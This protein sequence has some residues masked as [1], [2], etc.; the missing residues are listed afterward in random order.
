MR[1][2]SILLSFALSVFLGASGALGVPQ[3]AEE[4]TTALT[5][6][7]PICATNPTEHDIAVVEQYLNSDDDVD[8]D[9]DVDM[10]EMEEEKSPGDQHN[11]PPHHKKCRWK[12]CKKHMYKPIKVWFHIVYANKTREGGWIKKHQIK[13]QIEKVKR[14][15]KKS[16]LHW[17]IAGVNRIHNRDWFENVSSGTPQ[18]RAL[19]TQYRRGGA[20]TLNV[21]TVSFAKVP[22]LLG[23]AT[24]PWNYALDKTNDGVVIQW[25]TLPGG[26][27]PNY[28]EGAT[29]IHEIGHWTGLFHT[30]QGGCS[31]PGDYIFDTPAEASPAFGCPT[32]RDTCSARGLDPIHN[33]MDYTWDR[34]KHKYTCGQISRLIRILKLFRGLKKKM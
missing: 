32:G 26:S 9:D 21:Y 33:F 29:L 2:S 5:N 30:F 20:L 28:D 31:A 17:E 24:F 1:A 23:Y 3:P 10:L 6:A 14:D 25:Q 19:K 12:K 15:F 16:C 7:T 4:S 34:C 13:K 18:E 22:G 11:N 27:Y 8:D